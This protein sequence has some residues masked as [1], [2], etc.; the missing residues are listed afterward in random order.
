MKF[1][2][3]VKRLVFLRNLI[4]HEYYRIR[5]DELLEMVELLQSVNSLVQKVKKRKK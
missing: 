1:S 2:N 5:E 3:S 4:A